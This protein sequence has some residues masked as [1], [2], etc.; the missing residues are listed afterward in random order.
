MM[1][2]NRSNF[3]AT[4]K[5]ELHVHLEGSIHT[6]RLLTFAANQPDHPWHGL[7]LSDLEAMRKT[8]TFMEFIEMFKAGYRLLNS[9]ERFQAITEDMLADLENQG[10]MAADILYSPGVAFQMLGVNLKEIHRGI[11]AGLAQAPNIK[12]RFI[13][14]TVINL[15]PEFMRRTLDAVLADEPAF[16]SGFCVGGGDPNF[17]MHTIV[18]LF[19][20]A[21]NAGLLC[22]AH[23]GEVDGPNNIHCLLEETDVKRIAHGCNA[24]KDPDLLKRMAKASL[25]VDV[26]ISSNLRTGAVKSLEEHPIQTFAEYGIPFTINTDDP[27]YFETDLYREYQLAQQLLPDRDWQAWAKESLRAV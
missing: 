6:P 21:Q 7:Q 26:C 1:E 5:A 20:Y 22:I 3:R 15:G 10:V 2:L 27:F 12:T 19:A 25:V 17:N 16:L 14:D 4:P 23:A 18:D 24:V 9:A 13:L 11:A 8:K